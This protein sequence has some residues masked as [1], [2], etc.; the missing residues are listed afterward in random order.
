MILIIG[1]MHEEVVALTSKMSDVNAST[2]RDIAVTKGKLGGQDVVVA[3]SGVGKVNAAFT[4][5]ALIDSVKPDVVINIGSAGG[6]LQ[7]QSVGDI[8][9]ATNLQ[10]HDLDIGPSTHSDPRFIFETTPELV[11]VALEVLEA[12]KRPY[13]V[14][15]IVTGD[16]FITKH[17]PQF[18]T[19][20]TS[21]PQ[22]ICVEME[23]A[24]IAAVCKRSNTPFIV[25]RSLSDITHAEGNEI[26]FEEYLPVASENSA[27]ICLEFV[28]Q[29]NQ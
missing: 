16:Q 8:V 10:Y 19:I 29:L 17:Q 7:G 6:L 11:S 27:N 9:V 14:G 25:L 2:V 24:A 20:Q 23:A 26:S 22:A 12:S 1:A 4:T 21:F 5:T 15:K 13:H 28:T 3:L 18:K